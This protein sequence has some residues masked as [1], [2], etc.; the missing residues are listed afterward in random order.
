MG[1][2]VKT[3]PFI[4]QIHLCNAEH[5]YVWLWVPVIQSV[6][7]S[8]KQL[9]Q[10]GPCLSDCLLFLLPPPPLNNH[11]HAVAK[12]GLFGLQKDPKPTKLWTSKDKLP[13]KSQ[14]QPEVIQTV[15]D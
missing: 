13:E 15:K 10:E 12:P 5:N 14:P 9:S 11:K 3:L 1:K 8:Y 4:K 2:D 7:I 6:M